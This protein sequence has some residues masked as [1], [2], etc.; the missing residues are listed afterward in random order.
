SNVAFLERLIRHPAVV[1]G[2]IDTGY[3][4]RHL[5][6]FVTVP[7]S[8]PVE[9]LA[10]AAALFLFAEREAAQAEATASH[11]P[12]S[13]WALGDGWRM[14]LPARQPV[15]L[16][17]RDQTLDLTAEGHAAQFTLQHGAARHDVAVVHRGERALSLRIDGRTVRVGTR[18]TGGDFTVHVDGVR[19]T[20]HPAAPFGFEG[21]AES[22]SDRVRAPMPGRIVALHVEAGAAISEQQPLLVMEAMKMELT[23]RAPQAGSVAE[24][25]VEVGQIVE[26]DAVLAVL[27]FA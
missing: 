6:E 7:E 21:G 20:L 19:Y 25:R 9:A 12:H 5:D 15:R 18:E 27:S 13:P 4:D 17:W 14:G 2:R 16:Q 1:E 11:D 23:L 10:A 26:A 22:G 24:I 3:L 8:P